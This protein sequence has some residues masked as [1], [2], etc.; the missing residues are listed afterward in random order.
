MGTVLLIVDE[1]KKR[2]GFAR[3]ARSSL[4]LTDVIPC[5]ESSCD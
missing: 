3:T 2:G 5:S 4:C 1:I